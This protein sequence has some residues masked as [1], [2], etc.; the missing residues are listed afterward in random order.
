[1]L[2]T[3]AAADTTAVLANQD[4][5]HYWRTTYDILVRPAGARSPVEENYGLVEAN[6]LSGIAGGITVAQYEMIRNMPDVEIAA[7]VA[8]LGYIM[9]SI[10]VNIT[11][12]LSPGAYELGEILVVDD[13]IHLR[14][15][16]RSTRYY[17]GWDVPAQ[18]RPDDLR[19]GS[20]PLFSWPDR[21]PEASFIVALLV[22][23]IDPPQEAELAGIDQ[24]I[25]KGT[26]LTTEEPLHS[27]RGHHPWGDNPVTIYEIPVLINV[28]PYVSVTV[29]AELKRLLLPPEV[30]S[31]EAVRAKGGERY[32]ASLPIERTVGIVAM[33]GQSLY[34]HIVESL[35]NSDPSV[36]R[37]VQQFAAGMPG[38]LN[39]Q[40][41]QPPFPYEAPVLE[42]VPATRPFLGFKSGTEVAYREPD[43]G[44]EFKERFIVRVK[45]IFDIERIPKPADMNRVPLET[46]FPPLA[47][48]RYDEEGQPVIPRTIYPT[49]N[50]A[51]YI[52]PPPLVLTTLGAA[53]L[54][55]GDNCISAIRVRVDGIDKLTPQAQ[56]KIE[57]VASEI[58][59]RTGLDVDIMV[60]SSPRRILV[61]VPGIG[62]VEEQWVQKNVTLSYQR[63]IQFG[64][65][66]L[67]VALL[68]T[69]GLFAADMAWAD[70][71]ARQPVLA[72]QSAL[73]WR[74][75]TLIVHVL[76]R[77]ILIGI[78]AGVGGTALAAGTLVLARQLFP[79]FPWLVGIPLLV[80]AISFLGSFYPALQVT[81][82]PPIP[83][84]QIAGLRHWLG[85]GECSQSRLGMVL[86]LAHLMLLGVARCWRR[87]LLAGITAALSAGL[88]VLLVGVVADREGYLSG[89]LLG[90]YILVRIEGYHWGLVGVGLGLAA[91]GMGNSMLAG[92]LERRREIGVLRAVGWRADTVARLFLMEG[93][94]LGL[95]GGAVGTA[96]GLGA[97]L[98]LCQSLG[99]GVLMAALVGLGIPTVIGA[100]AAAYPAIMAAKTPPAE[101]SR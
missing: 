49:L 89:T 73:G 62:Y 75:T 79:S 43:V 11:Q 63:R 47:T 5:T 87:S 88:L 4:L 32:L 27:L 48:L 52:Q 50:P 70:L 83:L 40:E 91:V 55:A 6:Y 85:Q 61:R 69:G 19:A 41:V 71:L 59:R 30:T 74:P 78:G 18:L 86:S 60:G 94:T 53:Q 56:H 84:L 10:P 15:N 22:A 20:L 7:P 23:G 21:P 98:V 14:R 2:W 42:I 8:M 36:G 101:A 100:V 96:L 77:A 44:P 97:Y 54:I 65:L 81:Q 24:A 46:Y 31:F 9:E 82:V 12:T 57:A 3:V 1:M 35:L 28:T 66:L 39:Y 13:G 26:Y 92:V 95:L 17:I 93:A 34:L 45:G 76:R 72:L 64:H 51:G 90:E 29:Q 38:R 33:D 58:H 80:T 37:T 67:T 16:S 68:V 99:V 25:L